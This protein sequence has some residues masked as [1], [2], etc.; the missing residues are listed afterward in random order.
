MTRPAKLSGFTARCTTCQAPF[1]A[2]ST[3]YVPLKGQP[4]ELCA[5]CYAAWK[6]ERK[7]A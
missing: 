1:E 6:A 5:T 4:I 7:A 2:W 3:T